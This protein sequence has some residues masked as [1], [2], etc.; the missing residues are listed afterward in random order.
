MRGAYRAAVALWGLLA[1]GVPCSPRVCT[2]CGRTTT[3][4]TDAQA[5]A[6]T[7]RRTAYCRCGGRLIHPGQTWTHTARPVEFSEEPPF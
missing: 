4:L 3:R 1:P 6:I 7:A 2:G 5:A